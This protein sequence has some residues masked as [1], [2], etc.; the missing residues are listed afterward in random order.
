MN[1]KLTALAIALA[2]ALVPAQ[3]ALAEPFA[4]YGTAKVDM[5]EMP[6]TDI[7]FDVNYEDPKQLNILY[8]FIKNTKKETK[9]KGSLSR[10]VRN[11][12]R[13]PKRTTRNTRTSSTTWLTWRKTVWNSRCAT[14]R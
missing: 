6:V 10:T 4:P 14:T 13:S 3:A 5:H 12:A 7:V 11:C 2:I 9:G 1:T 8:H